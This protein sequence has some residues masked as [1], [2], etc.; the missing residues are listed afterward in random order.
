MEAVK[1][2]VYR[3]C[4]FWV[5]LFYPKISVRG[6]ENLPG[7]SCVVVGNHCQTNGPI[8][9]EIYFPGSHYIW[10]AGDMMTL[11]TVPAYAFKDFWSDKPKWTHWFYKLLS[12][13]IAP[14]A[15]C[16]FSK[17]HTI[18]VYRDRRIMTTLRLTMTRLKEGANV[19]I[20]PE[21]DEPYDHI[22]QNFLQ[23]FVDVA[24]LYYKQTGKRLQFVPMY[25]APKMKTI[26]LLEPVTFDPEAPI[27]AERKRICNYLMAAI[28]AHATALPRHKVICY[29]KHLNTYNRPMEE[30]SH[31][32]A[33]S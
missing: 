13:L 19:I 15:A 23:G 22:L 27:E 30:S 4:L 11:K 17:A 2:I 9:A 33:G 29:R 32:K 14:L 24:R 18:P 26:Y 1:S 25:L 31:E 7:E 3:F 28:S 5:K 20:F 10:C 21:H 8:A 12:Y 6:Q 16:L